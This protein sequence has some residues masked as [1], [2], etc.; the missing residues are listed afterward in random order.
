[1]INKPKIGEK[2]NGCGICCRNQVCMNGAYVL[3]LVDT[4]GETVKRPCPAIVEN[5]DGSISVAVQMS[6]EYDIDIDPK[7][8]WSS[9]ENKVEQGQDLET[10]KKD[11]YNRLLSSFDKYNTQILEA[12]ST[13][14]ISQFVDY[15]T[16][17]SKLNKKNSSFEV[18]STNVNE[19]IANDIISLKI[20]GVIV[21]RKKSRI[22]FYKKSSRKF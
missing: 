11:I 4:L 18:L 15:D 7:T 22:Y 2:C 9:L 19:D 10:L 13:E 6:N 16:F 20:R 5:K 1:M 8:M 12:S 3:K 21:N 14:K 17:V